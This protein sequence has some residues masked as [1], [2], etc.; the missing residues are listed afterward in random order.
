MFAPLY[1]C[2]SED[3]ATCCDYVVDGVYFTFTFKDGVISEHN[4]KYQE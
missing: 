4:E 1:H 2:W 3:C